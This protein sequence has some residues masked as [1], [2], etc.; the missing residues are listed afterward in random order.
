L[1]LI[2]EV[3]GLARRYSLE[4]LAFLT[5]TFVE[6]IVDKNEAERRYNS[7][8]TNVLDKRYP[9]P[10]IVILERQDR[11]AWHFH[12]LVVVPVDIRTGFDHDA[13]DR[14]D[15]RSACPW[16][17]EEW[18]LWR[19]DIAP[20]Y[21]FGRC[22]MRPVKK[23]GDIMALYLA[24]YIGK[25]LQNRLESDKGKRLVRYGHYRPGGRGTASLRIV[26]GRFKRH[27][28]YTQVFRW[29]LR[30]WALEHGCFRYENLTK[31]FGKR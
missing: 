13:V 28:P 17:R 20:G 11:G 18:R 30:K 16:L 12:L 7:L 27:T 29:K 9:Q 24:K 19:E 3:E 14:K 23:T 21:G 5:L 1:Q 2:L 15:Y 22:E 31:C 4:R 26:Q 10:L 6:N 25:C 8:K